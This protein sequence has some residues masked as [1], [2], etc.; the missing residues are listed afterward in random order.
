MGGTKSGA[1]LARR[2]SEENAA[3]TLDTMGLKQTQTQVRYAEMMLFNP[4]TGLADSI[5]RGPVYCTCGTRGEP[6]SA[7]LHLDG[8]RSANCLDPP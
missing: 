1:L 2:C 8:K 5:P 6:R 4:P 7:G 3:P